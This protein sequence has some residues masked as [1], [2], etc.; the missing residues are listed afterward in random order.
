MTLQ[1]FAKP[2]KITVIQVY[3]PTANAME[4]EIEG[5]YASIKKIKLQ[6]K[7]PQKTL[8]VHWVI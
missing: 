7:C 5:F 4:L 2:L 6:S 1:I 3:A 8:F